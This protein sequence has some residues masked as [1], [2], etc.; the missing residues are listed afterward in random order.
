MDLTTVSKV[1]RFNT[2]HYFLTLFGG[3]INLS[4][5]HMQSVTNNESSTESI[6]R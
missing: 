1:D 4:H 3:Q 2:L 6:D 5:R